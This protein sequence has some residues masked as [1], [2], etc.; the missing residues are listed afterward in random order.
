VAK[1]VLAVVAEPT[2]GAAEA[3]EAALDRASNAI[4]AS[5]RR[6]TS[7]MKP[8]VPEPAPSPTVTKRA[9]WEEFNTIVTLMNEINS[10]PLGPARDPVAIKLFKYITT[11]GPFLRRFPEFYHSALNKVLEF[12]TQRI[13]DALKEV[14]LQTENFLV[15]LGGWKAQPDLFLEVDPLFMNYCKSYH[16]MNPVEPAVPAPASAPV[17]EDMVP[18]A[19]I[20]SEGF[21]GEFKT[22]ADFMAKLNSICP[23]AARYPVAIEM[24][25]YIMTIEPFLR[26][27]PKFSET[28][29][30]KVIEFK[31]EN[32]SYA[33][34]DVLLK[35][36]DFLNGLHKEPTASEDPWCGCKHCA[37]PA[38]PE[39]TTL[40]TTYHANNTGEYAEFLEILKDYVNGDCWAI[41]VNDETLFD[42]YRDMSVKEYIEL[43]ILHDKISACPHILFVKM[44]EKKKDSTI[45]I[46]MYSNVSL[47][48]KITYKAKDETLT[49]LATSNPERNFF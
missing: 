15:R 6:M 32:I 4:H 3:H 21:E 2:D 30:K 8:A 17:E 47:V 35:A 10:L 49:L 44:F 19:A 5:V 26:R 31:A 37:V 23:A 36:E 13:S 1:P 12:K 41:K 43:S 33:L 38:A 28:C 29:L 27:F 48:V 14:L 40:G 22:I 18:S 42:F 46:D 45:M 25:N 11:I 39:H 7:V 34:R 24:F 9:Y 20:I 16:E